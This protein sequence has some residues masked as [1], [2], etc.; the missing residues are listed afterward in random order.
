MGYDP[1]TNCTSCLFGYVAST[2][3]SKTYC[4]LSPCL[5]GGTCTNSASG[6]SCNCVNGYTGTTCQLTHCDGN[7]C[8]HGTCTHTASSFTCSCDFGYNP[9]T[10]CAQTYCQT[11]PC[12]AC[13][14]NCSLSAT[15]RTC[16]CMPGWG[17]SICTGKTDDEFGTCSYVYNSSSCAVAA[18]NP[19]ANQ[20]FAGTCVPY[21]GCI[22]LHVQQ[23]K[24]RGTGYVATD[25]YYVYE[26]QTTALSQDGNTLALG[27]PL[28][29][30]QTGAVWVLVR[31]GS[32]WSQQGTKLV[33]TGAVGPARQGWGLALSADGNTLASS[34]TDDN[35]YTGAAWVFTR[36]AGVWTQQGSKLVGTGITGSQP[37][38]GF[39]V[40]LSADGNTLALSSPYDNSNAG[41]VWIFTRSAGVWTQ[42]GAKLAGP[43]T[44][45]QMGSSLALS[46]DGSTLTTG[47]PRDSANFGAVLVFTSNAGVWSQQGS[48]L[49]GTGST[50][51]AF[52]G[53]S[54][55][56]SNDGNTLASGGYADNS[57]NGA[58]WLF[59]RVGSTWTQQG[60]KLVSA[61][62]I[63]SARQG[64]SV[65]LSATATRLAVGGSNDNSQVGAAWVWT[66]AQGS[67]TQYG[68]KIVGTNY[69]G[70][71][72]P[73]Q[74]TSVSLSGDGNTLSVGGPLDFGQI[75]S[76]WVFV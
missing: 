61:E 43:G 50:G 3:C 7:P 62:H 59:G 11:N 76:V 10:N 74:G 21:Q 35:S 30:S 69:T 37:Q 22:G 45:S 9:S 17:G 38:Q 27:G 65:S 48:K 39:A 47:A 15:S 29:N 51:A 52:Q 40:A 31:S 46:A 23:A 53:T 75:G 20:P 56:L 19:C 54:V 71:Y 41:A 36:S 70:A 24:L 13:T 58:V 28:D 4:D 67:W 16:N 32:T 2:N 55:A 49:V 42:Q 8:N 63:G 25:P 5:N 33:G 26:G 57:N 68:S 14:S 12:G 60:S 6:S 18:G 64:V 66:N 44:N 73:N 72:N 1:A 34:G